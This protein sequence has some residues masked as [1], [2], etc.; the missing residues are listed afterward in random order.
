MQHRKGLTL[1]GK[2]RKN[3]TVFDW[4]LSEVSKAPQFLGLW[5]SVWPLRLSQTLR[6]KHAPVIGSGQ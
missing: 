1:D 4:R 3:R 6:R 2:M 5:T